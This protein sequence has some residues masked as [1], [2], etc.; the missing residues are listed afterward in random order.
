[1]THEEFQRFREALAEHLGVSERYISVQVS[2]HMD[3]AAFACQERHGIIGRAAKLLPNGDTEYDVQFNGT[4][5][6]RC[7]AWH[8]EISVFHCNPA[9]ADAKEEAAGV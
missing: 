6:S 7:A 1:M 2:V 5:W 9:Q 8:N 4:F 3:N